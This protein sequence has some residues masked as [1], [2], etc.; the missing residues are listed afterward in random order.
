[1]YLKSYAAALQRRVA[2]IR[3]KRAAEQAQPEATAATKIR[4]WYAALQPGERKER[5]LMD[6][7]VRAIGVAPQVLGPALHEAGFKRVRV[8]TNYGE[9][10]RRVW[11][12]PQPDA[13]VSIV[14]R[15][16]ST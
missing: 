12:P 6:E 5:Y 1:M 11:L 9:P 2:E 16:S 14:N 15:G 4:E 7:L 13:F 10:H 8:W 3:A